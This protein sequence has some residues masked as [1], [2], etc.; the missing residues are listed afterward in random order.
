MRPRNDFASACLNGSK[1][2]ADPGTSGCLSPAF[3][4]CL[5]RCLA[6]ASMGQTPVRSL[7]TGSPPA[8]QNFEIRDI[9]LSRNPEARR[10]VVNPM[11]Q[12]VPGVARRI[13]VGQGKL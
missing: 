4:S 9:P 12:D 5:G 6:T 10:I 2:R 13:R 11:S 8:S 7:V 3:V 1:D